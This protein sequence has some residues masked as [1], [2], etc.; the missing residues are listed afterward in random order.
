MEDWTLVEAGQRVQVI[1]KDDDE[2]GV[3]GLGT[4]FFC[5]HG[6]LAA[7]LGASPGAITSVSIMM[8]IFETCFGSHFDTNDLQKK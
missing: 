5:A 2:S 8:D 3:L 6:T 1:K 4:D 7:L